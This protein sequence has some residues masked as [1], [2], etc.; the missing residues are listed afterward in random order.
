MTLVHRTNHPFG[1]TLIETI[2]VIVLLSAAAIASSLML[3]GQWVA[4]RSVAA[5]TTEVAET[6]DAARNTAIANQAAIR[7]RRLRRGG[8]EQLLVTEMAG[9]FGPG[10]TRTVDLGADVR[11]RGAPTEIRFQPTGGSNRGLNWTITRSRSRG[12]VN[13]SPADGHVTKVSP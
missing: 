5:I 13:V 1:V 6:L 9:P 3:D 2:M 4:R 10:R 7:V 11:L 12:Q 8:T